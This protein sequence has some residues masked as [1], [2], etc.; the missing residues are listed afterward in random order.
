MSEG[1]FSPLFTSGATSRAL[2]DDAWIRAMLEVEAALATAEARVGVI[3]A[4]AAEAIVKACESADMDPAEIGREARASGTPVAALVTQLRERLDDNAATYVHWGATSQDV[5]DTAMML[6]SARASDTLAADIERVASNCALLAETH[7]TTLMAGRTL[8]QQAVPISFGLK[9]AGWL[10]NV[11]DARLVLQAARAD[12]AVQLGGAAGTLA[13]LGDAG[14]RVLS[15]LAQELDLREPPAPWHTA[16]VR[17]AHLGAALALVAGAMAKI[18]GDLTLLSQTE[19]AELAEGSERERGGSSTIPQKRNPV[20]ATLAR[21][22]ALR[23][24]G[25]TSTL[26]AAM[27]QEHERAAGAWHAEWESLRDALNL[28]AAATAWVEEALDGLEVK[29]DQMWLNLERGGDSLMAEHVVFELAVHVGRTEAE[30]LVKAAMEGAAADDRSLR[31]QLLDVAEVT[32]HMTPEAIDA[33]LDPERYLG[34]SQ[35]FVRRSLE[36][37][38]KEVES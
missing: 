11:L 23:V 10:N 25:A 7:A 31:H 32:R 33:A 24:Q 9:S 22:C 3:P 21:A 20:E 17:V 16:R 38:R 5:L 15:Q 34:S 14:E 37:F 29:Q 12:L 36:R 13:A 30:R 4:E 19:I 2:S 27:A 26:F 8:M 1:L 6:V 28:T 18:A 35:I